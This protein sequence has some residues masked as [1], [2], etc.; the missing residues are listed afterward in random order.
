MSQG[1]RD[2]NGEFSMILFLFPT[3]CRN[4]FLSTT[5]VPSG[6]CCR[7]H[8]GFYPWQI[9]RRVIGAGGTPVF[10]GVL[11]ERSLDY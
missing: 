2:A 9:C 6:F 8:T 3:S 11:N 1:E 5:N 4:R 10:Q 7:W